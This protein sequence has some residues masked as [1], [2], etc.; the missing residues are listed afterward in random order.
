MKFLNIVYDHSI[1]TGA[2]V[3]ETVAFI[4]FSVIITN[5]VDSFIE[6]RIITS[7][8]PLLVESLKLKFTK[9]N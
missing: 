9:R 4:F 7:S 3:R 6:R 2:Y 1:T 8:Y 5:V